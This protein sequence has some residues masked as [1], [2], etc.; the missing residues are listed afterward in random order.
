MSDLVNG[1]K[2]VNLVSKKISSAVPMVVLCKAVQ[3]SKCMTQNDDGGFT[4]SPG[5]VYD[6]RGAEKESTEYLQ[7]ALTIA[8]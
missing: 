5:L 4:F 7:K 3:Y 1:W 8:K 6:V 2:W